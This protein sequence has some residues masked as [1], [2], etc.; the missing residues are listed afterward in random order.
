[1]KAVEKKL[2]AAEP[3]QQ[4]AYGAALVGRMLPNYALFAELAQAGDKKAFQNIL[5]LVWEYASGENQR[6]DFSR[7]QDKLEAITPDPAQFDMYG[8]WPALDAVVALASLL[9]ACEHFDAQEIGSIGALSQATIVGFLEARGVAN[10]GSEQALL[11]AD[12]QFGEDV[13]QCLL[14]ESDNNGRR[15]AVR[16]LRQWMAGLE[17]SNIGLPNAD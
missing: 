6:I 15:Q 1:V 10:Q 8:V 13:L 12:M 5:D 9:S 17:E 3:W 7:Q 16:A 11:L 14:Q 4:I 2:E